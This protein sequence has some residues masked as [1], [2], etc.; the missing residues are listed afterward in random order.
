MGNKAVITALP[1]LNSLN[2]SY[3][4]EPTASNCAGDVGRGAVTNKGPFDY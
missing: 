3:N 4:F 1:G 2:F